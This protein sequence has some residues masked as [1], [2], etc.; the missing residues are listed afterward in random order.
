MGCIVH[1]SAPYLRSCI[2]FQPWGFTQIIYSR[3]DGELNSHYECTLHQGSSW[4]RL[5]NDGLIFSTL[6]LLFMAGQFKLF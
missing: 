2:G 5:A 6:R 4:A 3:G 1:A